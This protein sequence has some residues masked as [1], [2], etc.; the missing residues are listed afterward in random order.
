M[1]D[2]GKSNTNET[3]YNIYINR[4]LSWLDF[5][6]RVLCEAKDKCNPVFERI[7]FLSITSSNLD[8]FFMIRVASLKDMH[9]AKY[10][11]KDFSGMTPQMQLDAIVD[12]AHQFVTRQYSTYNRSIK[13]ALKK[14]GLVIIDR[15]ENLDED[16]KK[17]VDEYFDDYIYPV[18]TP[19]SVDSSR[20]FPLVCNKMLNI[21]ALI[22]DKEHN[23]ADFVTVQI[24]DT[25]GRIV[26]IPSCGSEK[27]II[28]LEQVVKGNLYKLFLNLP[29]ICAF[30]YRIIRDAN[31]SIDEDEATDLLVEIKKQ[32]KKRQR[33]E[34]IRLEIENKADTRLIERLKREFGIK[35]KDIYRINGPLDFTFLMK[36]YGM[37][38]FDRYKYTPY[39]PIIPNGLEDKKLL[40]NAI[41]KHDI[42]LHHPYDSFEP[43]ME[44]IENAAKDPSVLAIKQTLYRVSS[45]S[46]IIHSLTKAAKNGKQVLV[47]VELKARFDEKNNINWA[48]KLEKAGCHVIYGLHGLKTHSKITLIVRKENNEI[49]QY[50]HLGTGNYNDSTAKLYTDM[51]LLTCN[52]KICQ[53]ASA[54][55]NMI[56][57]GSKPLK[58]NELSIAPF[59]LRQDFLSLIENEKKNAMDGKEGCIIAKINSL[60]DLQIINALYEASKAGV[61]IN[62]IVRGI[63]CLKAGIKGVSDNI[64]VRSV[65]GKFLEHSRI[66]YFHNNGNEKIY[67]SSADWMPRNLDKRVEILFEVEDNSIKNNIKDILDIY[68]ND[69]KRS[70]IMKPDGTYKKVDKRGKPPLDCQ[71]Y[72][73]QYAMLDD[74]CAN[75]NSM[76]DIPDTDNDNKVRF[77]PMTNHRNDII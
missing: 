36:I 72:F 20:P 32:L 47:L 43:V 2:N 51:G 4:E 73:W 70:H 54:L 18:L 7:K 44:L 3:N 21:G 67:L 9:N 19:M 23:V 58:W 15:Y 27:N 17:Y 26:E 31:L 16:Q 28:L 48:L 11:K 69:T 63:C 53:D 46:P 61:K 8:E 12:K 56:S 38:G 57:G 71:E 66:F 41:Q 77:V 25:L 74:I 30:T 65:V 34:V 49:K 33:G 29:I 52:K 1:P 62:L 10:T 60:C 75:K 40:F 37:D 64:T 50:V 42:F 55:F 13:P 5:N 24:P 68:L 6:Y 14:A 35:E 22:E 59:W 45:N 39:T 76:T